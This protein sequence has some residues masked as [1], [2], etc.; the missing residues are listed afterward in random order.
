M[1]NLKDIIS[2]ESVKNEGSRK[3]VIE[4]IKSP[5][6]FFVLA[7][8]IIEAFIASCLIFSDLDPKNKQA[9]LL[10]GIGL[11]LLIVIIVAI[12]AWHKPHNLT[13]NGYAHLIDSGKVPFGTKRDEVD[14]FELKKLRP[15]KEKR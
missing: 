2:K 9:G 8:L 1:F 12:F 11:F 3:G 10:I 5:L 6:G 14:Y 13:Y 15:D 7:L 4:T